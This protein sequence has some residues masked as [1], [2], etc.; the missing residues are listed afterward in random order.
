M[1]IPYFLALLLVIGWI[2]FENQALNRRA[3]WIPLFILAILPGIRSSK[4]GTDTENYT[5]NYGFNTDKIYYDFND[6]VEKGYQLLDYFILNFSNN[7]FW[8]L[9]LTAFFIVFS[10][11]KLIKHYSL[12]YMFSVLLFITLGLYTFL[13]NGLRQALAMAIMTYSVKYLLEKKMIAYFVVCFFA[14]AFHISALIM[15]PFYFLVNLKIKSSYK[16]ILVG[17]GSFIVSSQFIQYM[18]QGNERYE[19]YTE[20]GEVR[21]IYTLGFYIVIAIFIFLA[22]IK[23]KI[24]DEFSI[25]LSE[26]YYMGIVMIIPVALF[27]TNPSGPQRIMSYFIWP[28][29]FL[30]PFIFKKINNTFVTLFFVILCVV[31]YFLTVMNFSDLVPYSLNPNL[32]FF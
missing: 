14:S 9:F 31:Y 25:K 17:L 11:L 30:L 6:N 15:I 28:I 20:G 3:F 19:A 4:V 32:K 13:F 7:Y 2:Y 5:Y 24:A 29:L 21:G 1:V 23:Y 10:Y 8:L 16:V 26:L 12:N 18:A 27:G 22:H